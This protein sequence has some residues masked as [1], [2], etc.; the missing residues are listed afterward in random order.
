MAAKDIY[1]EHVRQA[2]EKD[3]WKITDD[4]LKLPWAGTQVKIDLGAERQGEGL[5]SAE[6]GTRKIAVEIKSFVSRSRVDDLENALGQLRL[7]RHVL[8]LQQ[9]ERELY[10]AIREEVYQNFFSHPDVT[11]FLQVEQVRLLLFSPATEVILQWI[12]WTN[13]EPSSSE[14]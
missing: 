7:Y 10:L 6:K 12:D 11:A 3:G 8:H 9:P 2:L 14:A 1:H 4:P 13:T 5:I